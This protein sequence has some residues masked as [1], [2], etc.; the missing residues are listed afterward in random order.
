MERRDSARMTKKNDDLSRPKMKN[1][2]QRKKRKQS[3]SGSVKAGPDPG[4]ARGAFLP[5]RS[6]TAY[7]RRLI[8][9]YT[10]PK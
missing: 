2:Q 9:R 5:G 1:L 7:W 10:D 6:A 4:S 8:R 3:K